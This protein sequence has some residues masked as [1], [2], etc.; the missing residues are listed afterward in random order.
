MG[1]RDY[2][3]LFGFSHRWLDLGVVTQEDLH[4]L[5]RTYETCD[6][7]S[8][9]HYRYGA[10]RYYLHH[11]RSLT[12]VMAEALYDLGAADSDPMMGEA[13]MADIVR[14]PECPASVVS[15]SN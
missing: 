6:D 10:F 15:K 14:L 2:Q 13:I 11:H 3:S 12:S 5:G 8:T 4:Q 7:K 1:D 9:E